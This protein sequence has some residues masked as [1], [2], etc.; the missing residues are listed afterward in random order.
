MSSPLFSSAPRRFRVWLGALAVLT[1]ATG[2]GAQ[3]SPATSAPVGP[4]VPSSP[5]ISS[6]PGRETTISRGDGKFLIHI[7]LAN[8]EELAVARIATERAADPRVRDF[9]HEIVAAHEAMDG[10]IAGLAAEKTVTLD[11]F[12]FMKV[13]RKWAEKEKAAGFDA[14]FVREMISAHKRAIGLFEEG[15]KLVTDPDVAAFA[16]D[17]LPALHDHLRRAE[18]LQKLLE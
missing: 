7:A 11:A 10:E 3:S 8:S 12:D 6:S 4:A 18:D 16:R 13:N 14:A 5:P 2:A 15:A 9:A 17:Q 1:A